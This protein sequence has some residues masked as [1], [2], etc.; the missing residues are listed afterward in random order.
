M[1]LGSSQ[2]PAT[3]R[4]SASRVSV[5]RRTPCYFPFPYG[6][7][8]SFA[9]PR[10]GATPAWPALT[11]PST[12]SQPHRTTRALPPS[13]APPALLAYLSCS[14]CHVTAAKPSHDVS[15]RH[16]DYSHNR[17]AH[18]VDD[19]EEHPTTHRHGRCF[20]SLYLLTAHPITELCYLSRLS[21]AA[22]R[23]LSLRPRK[24]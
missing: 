7:F 5:V 19:L 13:P 18:K 11:H 22:R 23:R 17:D 16:D 6:S 24:G 21:S 20:D 15:G 4:A 9:T 12:L 8:P 14:V 1:G 2:P 3:K 10:F